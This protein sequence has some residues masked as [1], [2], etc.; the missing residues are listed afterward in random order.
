MNEYFGFAGTVL[1]LDLTERSFRTETLD[2]NA[3]ERF[4][5]GFGMN[6]VL[7]HSF[8]RPGTDPLGPDNPV[9]L[10]A[11]PLVGT[12]APGS[13]RVMATT[14]FPLTGAVAA[15]SGSMS[16]GARMKWAGYDHIV[17]LGQAASPVYVTV[18]SEA[19]AFHD[20]SQL[21]GRGI[22][23]TASLLRGRHG[24]SGSVIAIGPAGEALLPC[25]MALTDA[26]G[27]LGR[28]GLGA[29]MGAKKL[30]AIYI[31]GEGPEEK[32]KR[33]QTYFC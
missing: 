4:L 27:T 10:G 20:A 30:K 7:F 13:S 18:S 2:L 16:F 6:N 29:V 24:S 31:V 26:G 33:G 9:I 14:K 11:G 12:L 1:V 3:A 8:S 21:G 23:E 28:G 5:G 17:I 32:R 15:A 25:A 19:A 22:H